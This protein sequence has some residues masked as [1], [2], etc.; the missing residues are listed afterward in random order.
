[1]P[2]WP[3]GQLLTMYLKT[4]ESQDVYYAGFNRK[5]PADTDELLEGA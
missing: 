3:H 4:R 5:S 2:A 1:M